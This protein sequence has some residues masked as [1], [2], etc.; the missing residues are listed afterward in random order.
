MDSQRIVILGGRGMLGSDLTSLGRT[1]GLHFTSLDLPEFDI[2]NTKHLQEA[3]KDAKVVINCAA[4]TNVEKA[5]TEKDN[6]YKINAEAVGELGKAA[7][8]MGLWVL[9][10]STDFVFDGAKKGPYN[11][12]DQ[13]NPI[14]SYGKS[15]LEGEKLLIES[16]C[17]YC[18]IR[19]QWTYGLNGNNFV[20]KMVSAAMKNNE[21]RVVDDQVGSPTSTEE[22]AKAIV[23]LIQLKPTGLFHFASE[24]FTSR[25]GMAEFIFDKLNMPVQLKACKTSDFPSAAA[26]PLNSRFECSR[27]KKLLDEPIEPWQKPLQR[28]IDKIKLQ[29]KT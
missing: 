29:K 26:R 7:K 10:I 8:K 21:L 9:Q 5:E 19:L 6:A 12:Q 17:Q 1:K 20:T 2:T 11:E 23:R 27:I 13:P 22:A 24:G 25:F 28:Y 4:Y 14:N 15:K 18:I 16:G 3:L